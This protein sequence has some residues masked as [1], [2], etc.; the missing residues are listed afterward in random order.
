MFAFRITRINGLCSESCF[1]L[2]NDAAFR[3]VIAF[4]STKNLACAP[5][6]FLC[7]WVLVIL[8]KGTGAFLEKLSKLRVIRSQYLFP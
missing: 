1:T 4:C 6:H 7:L 2:D 8:G 5:P 3:V